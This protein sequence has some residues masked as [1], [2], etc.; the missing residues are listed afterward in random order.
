[1][2]KIGKGYRLKIL[3]VTIDRSHL[4]RRAV[5]SAEGD[6]LIM[7]VKIGIAILRRPGAV[8]F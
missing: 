2:V 1:M 4:T 3:H 8:W 5:I 7:Q 6:K